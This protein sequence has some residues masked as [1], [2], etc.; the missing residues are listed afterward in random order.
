[1]KSVLG[2]T[3]FR[4]LL[5]TAFLN[6]VAS[7]IAVVALAL[8]VYHQTGSAVGAAAFFLCAEFAPAFVSPFVVARLEQRA[9]RGVLVTLYLVE[10]CVFLVLALLVRD[11]SL[12][13]V[14][15]LTL[16][17][18]SIA[19]AARVLGRAA[20]VSITVRAGLM[21]E[22]N[23]V[24]NSSI[25]VAYMIGP[26]L[27]GLIVATAGT[28]AALFSDVGIFAA[29]ALIIATS[30]ALP[31]GA[32]ERQPAR[33]RLRAVARYAR[34]NPLIR[35]LIALEAVAMLFF[36][37]SIPVEVVFAQ[38]TLHAGA[39]SYGVLLSA[40]GV[41]AIAGS[42]L[43][44]RWRLRTS[45]FLIVLGTS[46]LGAG[47]LVMAAAPTIDVAIVGS[48]IGGFGNG[49]QIVAMR[50]ALQEATAADWM[51]LI[52]GVNESMFQAVPGAGILLGGAITATAGPRV[53]LA[54]GA[55]GSLLVAAAIWIGL[56]NVGQT[57]TS[58]RSFAVD[59][60]QSEQ[61]L[62][63]LGRQRG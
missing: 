25:S 48:G 18:G 8:L 29:S 58:E 7:S 38:R 44:A 9:A 34:T 39:G 22:G 3:A 56:R 59:Q 28:R 16:L 35:R 10:A 60:D 32:P 55:S 47:F 15:A 62:S 21:R 26:G 36:T 30:H 52:L 17:N 50:T 13:P 24:A 54:V 20:G 14:L 42:A 11:F 46:L 63:V 12:L 33:G 40:W 1:M 19:V 57:A 37:I 41:G 43:Y 31:S 23:A 2:I 27:G 45:R 53:A 49:I 51:A 4:R 61:R 6:E 5:A